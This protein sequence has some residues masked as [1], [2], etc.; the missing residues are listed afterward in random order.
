MYRRLVWFLCFLLLP[1]IACTPRR[2][3]AV[4]D[5][6]APMLAVSHLTPTNALVW[7]RCGGGAAV[8]IDVDGHAWQLPLNADSDY[9]QRFNLSVQ[10]GSRRVLTVSC[11]DASGTSRSITRH[12][13]AAPPAESATMIR[14]A[15]GGDVG[16]QNVC[17]STSGGYGILAAIARRSPDLFIGLGDM[18]Y[19]DDACLPT[20]RY[21]NPQIP[22]PA[23]ASTR[24]EFQDHW[25]YNWSDPSLAALLGSTVYFPVWDDHEIANDAG[26][27]HDMRSTAP[28]VHLLPPARQAFVDYNPIAAE[29]PFYRA[30]RWGQ[31]LEMFF[32]DQRSYRDAN[33]RPDDEHKS[34][35]GATQRRW[36][37]DSLQRS[38]ATWKLIVSSV[39]LAIPTC[40]AGHGCDGWANGSDSTG[41]ENELL[42]ILRALQQAEVRN[43]VVITTDVHFATGFRHQPFADDPEFVLHE[44]VTG[45]LNAGIFPKRDLDPTLHPTRLF[46]HGPPSAEAVST[47]VEAQRW[48]NFGQLDLSED[49]IL[50]V[51]VANGFG[52]T[53]FEE[54]LTPHR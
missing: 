20:G 37:I 4:D 9:T 24:T 50:R 53:V 23:A 1:C 21:G 54:T 36:L 10:A 17:R 28:D 35:L 41:F 5:R 22:G 52:E 12:V 14:L 33:S 46:F 48:F 26:P 27:Q 25:R 39:P 29:S 38:T 11:E 32:L 8:G 40:R 13:T 31:H 47:F 2:R 49:G 42:S 51:L 44:Y 45:P 34:M 43:L 18:I 3:F 16:G 30:S 7:V 15:W 19:G 6:T